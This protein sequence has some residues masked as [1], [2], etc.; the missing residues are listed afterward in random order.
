M[1]NNR[2]GCDTSNV[3]SHCFFCCVASFLARSSFPY[4]LYANNSLDMEMFS[5]QGLSPSLSPTCGRPDD[6]FAQLFQGSGLHYTL[7]IT[8]QLMQLPTALPQGQSW[9]QNDA[10][11]DPAT[12][13]L[14]A[15][16][17]SA[18]YVRFVNPQP[19]TPGSTNY[20]PNSTVAGWL[21]DQLQGLWASFAQGVSQFLQVPPK[22]QG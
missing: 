21:T 11:Y 13:T 8:E 6:M 9:S 7:P 16:G 3:V 14:C 5:S 22:R 20:T 19:N 12:D 2:N 1:Q 10:T 4:P 17:W 15:G 18:L